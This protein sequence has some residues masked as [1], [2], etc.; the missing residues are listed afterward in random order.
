[1]AE[2]EICV[3]FVDGIVQYTFLNRR[4]WYTHATTGSSSRSHIAWSCL[5]FTWWFGLSLDEMLG[6]LK[7]PHGCE[8]V[9]RVQM[10]LSPGLKMTMTWRYV[11]YWLLLH[12]NSLDMNWNFGYHHL[13]L[14]ILLPFEFIG[15]TIFSWLLFNFYLMFTMLR[16]TRNTVVLLF[17]LQND[18]APKKL[19]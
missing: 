15:I 3:C 5:V 7:C 18:F 13:L 19:W 12:I 11:M 4:C 2:L 14:R 8:G 1:M 17:F 10:K 6:W 16:E 9:M